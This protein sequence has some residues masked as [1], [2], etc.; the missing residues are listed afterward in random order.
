MNT[1]K[2]REFFDSLAPEWDN[3][4]THDNYKLSKI[5]DACSINPNDRVLDIAC[6]TGIMFK[7]IL[8][9]KPSELVGIDISPNMIKIAQKKHK[10][11]R[12]R[13]ICDDL[14]N[15]NL[16]GF[17]RAIIYSA[18]PHF[19]DKAGLA[20]YL[21]KA[22]KAGGR[23]IIAHSQSKEE[24][25][26]LH[27]GVAKEVSVLLKSAKEEQCHFVN[28]FNIDILK[29]TKNLYIISGTKL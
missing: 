18:Y 16:E 11:N 20:A 3:I 2:I 29:D 23:F 26:A 28:N 24:I 10:D 4:C 1:D 13:L 21:S 6:G 22:L 5:S 27:K 14:F 19:S 15:V 9:K 17:D 12:I 25:N 8:E 7:Y